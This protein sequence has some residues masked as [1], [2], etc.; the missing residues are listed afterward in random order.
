VN[1]DKS[2]GIITMWGPTLRFPRNKAD[3][4]DKVKPEFTVQLRDESDGI[5]VEVIKTLYV[6]RKDKTTMRY[7]G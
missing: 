1:V 3:Q 7:G 5:M 4:E 2:I 6:L